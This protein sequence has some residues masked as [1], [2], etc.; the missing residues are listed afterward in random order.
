MG[1]NSTIGERLAQLR[2][3]HNMTQNSLAELLEGFDRYHIVKLE[4]GKVKNPK[5]E[6][7]AQIV[8]I[9]HTTYEWLETGNGAKSTK[10]ESAQAFN[11]PEAGY[12]NEYLFQLVETLYEN[13]DET[14][15]KLLI[16]E[17]ELLLNE[18]SMKKMEAM[19]YRND[20]AKVLEQVRN[21]R[22]TQ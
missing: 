5:R 1:I 7:L 10:D 20:M 17:L 8:Q 19:K 9:F 13:P 21:L 2:K 15:K 16:G 11:E 6:L 3:E 4:T 14:T 12:G 22:K 18:V